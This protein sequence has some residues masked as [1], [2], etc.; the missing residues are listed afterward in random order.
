MQTPQPK[1]APVHNRLIMWRKSEQNACSHM[2]RLLY[3]SIA[4]IYFPPLQAIFQTEALSL[5]DLFVVLSLAAVS[6]TLHE[7]RRVT[8][9]KVIQGQSRFVDE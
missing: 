9:R 8:E 5:R 1:N 7:V 6:F 4:L 3:C 2:Q